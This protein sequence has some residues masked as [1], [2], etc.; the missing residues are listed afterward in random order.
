MWYVYILLCSGNSLYTGIAKDPQ[1]RFQ[2][3]VRGTGGKY[4]R[5][6][7]P[8]RI[9]YIQPQPD[10]SAALRREAEIKSWTRDRKILRLNLSI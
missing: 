10:H 7:K 2:S 8:L 1:K 9:I 5:L 6:R 3:H 4:T